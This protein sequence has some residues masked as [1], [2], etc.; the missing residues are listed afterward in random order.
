MVR[1]GLMKPR[2]E[3]HEREEEG[4]CDS[5]EEAFVFMETRGSSLQ[6]HHALLHDQESE[7][8]SD[9]FVD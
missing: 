7:S 4:E 2:S 3:E 5:K 1:L 9:E 6:F 8:E